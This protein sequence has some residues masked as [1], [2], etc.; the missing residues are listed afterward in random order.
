M[1]TPTTAGTSQVKRR[2]VP[3]ERV[4]LL[5][6]DDITLRNI[7]REALISEGYKVEI[8]SSRPIG[9]ALV[10]RETLST[11]ITHSRFPAS[12]EHDLCREFMQ[13]VPATPFVLLSAIPPSETTHFSWKWKVTILR[14][15]S[16]NFLSVWVPRQG[17]GVSH[18]QKA[19]TSLATSLWTL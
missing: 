12:Q 9:L 19:S 8:V 16:K 7:I 18:A 3:I 1:V 4:L 17:R 11:R 10:G 13:A 2:T 15:S 5:V 14:L 6:E